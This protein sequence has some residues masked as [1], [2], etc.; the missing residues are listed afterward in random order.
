MQ[1]DNKPNQNEVDEL[2]KLLAAAQSNEQPTAEQ[3][4]KVSRIYTSLVFFMGIF[5]AVLLGIIVSGKCG[6]MFGGFWSL[7]MYLNITVTTLSNVFLGRDIDGIRDAGWKSVFGF[8]AAVC[9]AIA[10]SI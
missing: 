9:L 6:W 2:T 7:A 8:I 3:I 5:V 4:S 10:F 1:N